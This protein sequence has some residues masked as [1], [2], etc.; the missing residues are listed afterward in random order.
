MSQ[1]R[2]TLDFGLPDAAETY[3]FWSG[4]HDI[5]FEGQTYRGAG[6]LMAV[7]SAE[8]GPDGQPEITVSIAAGDAGLREALIEETG[9]VPVIVRWIYSS[10]NGLTW[11]DT[12][13]IVSGFLSSPL[14]SDGVYTATIATYSG[15]VSRRTPHRWS[16][17][18][19]RARNA[20]DGGMDDMRRLGRGI[21]I[22]WPP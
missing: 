18:D 13:L 2:W 21:E 3:R 1:P 15:D 10:D 17:E 8:I 14:L 5:L 9:P 7:S 4:D 16:A 12:G 6:Q 11:N 20:Q 22:G 19:Q